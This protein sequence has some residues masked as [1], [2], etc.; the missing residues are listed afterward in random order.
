MFSCL[1]T[2]A[3]SCTSERDHALIQAACAA[4]VNIFDLQAL[5]RSL[6]FFSRRPRCLILAPIPLLKSTNSPMRSRKLNSR[7]ARVLFLRPSMTRP[8]P[9]SRMAR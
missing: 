6:A 9:W 3:D 8:C 1:P 2:Q 7:A 4:I 5:V